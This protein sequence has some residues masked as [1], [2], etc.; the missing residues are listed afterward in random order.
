MKKTVNNTIK[1]TKKNI[2]A[3]KTVAIDSENVSDNP[4][5]SCQHTVAIIGICKND[6]N[7]AFTDIRNELKK[8]YINENAI[9][10][11]DSGD[12]KFNEKKIKKIISDSDKKNIHTIFLC[13][14][15]EISASILNIQQTKESSIVLVLAEVT[16]KNKHIEKILDKTERELAIIAYQN[17]FS[18]KTTI[19]ILN[20][21]HCTTMRLSEYRTDNNAIEPLLRDS[22]FLAIDL[23]AVRHSDGGTSLSP[24]GL[25][26]EE[27]CQIANCA[28][29]SN[30]VSHVNIIC[31]YRENIVT[32]KLI[33]QTIWH[34]A[35]GLSNRI[36]ENPS[37]SK[38]K[39]FIVNMENSSVNMVFYKSNITNRW[40][41]EVSS[42]NKTKIIACTFS[43]YQ[44]ACNNNIPAKW[45]NEMQ[46]MS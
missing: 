37:K 1:A 17:Y 24:N 25:Y 43:D 35:D 26:A 7:E 33:A 27:L 39:K 20:K 5:S 3:K 13:E 40:W 29:L 28:G 42:Q 31:N 34:F 8:L 23:A 38:F 30:T 44:C 36:V 12:I 6:T 9:T 22:N 45:I 2:K 32:S 21:N 4:K 10:L 19:N 14:N 18:D 11:I 15:D 41:I 16:Q 46:K